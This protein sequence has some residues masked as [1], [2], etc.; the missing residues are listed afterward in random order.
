MLYRYSILWQIE[1]KI[2]GELIIYYCIL[3]ESSIQKFNHS[4]KKKKVFKNLRMRKSNYYNVDDIHS[5][6]NPIC[7]YK[8]NDL[9]DCVLHMSWVWVCYQVRS[10]FKLGSFIFE[11]EFNN[12]QF[13]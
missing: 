9:F 5:K 2:V 1:Y 10:N 4:K 7:L 8:K 12:N 3:A 11:N 13:I 6:S